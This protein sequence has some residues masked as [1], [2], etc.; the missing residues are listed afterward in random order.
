MLSERAY[1]LTDLASSGMLYLV[2]FVGE[3]EPWIVA[4]SLAAIFALNELP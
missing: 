1:D 4:P 2:L 3:M